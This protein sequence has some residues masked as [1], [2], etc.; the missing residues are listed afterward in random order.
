MTVANSK[1]DPKVSTIMTPYAIQSTHSALNLGNSFLSVTAG[2]I[3]LP[4]FLL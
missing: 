2:L 1:I 3:L 4:L